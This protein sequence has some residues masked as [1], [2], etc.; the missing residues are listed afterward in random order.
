MAS[1]CG[2][3]GLEEALVLSTL[4]ERLPLPERTEIDEARFHEDEEGWLEEAR[5]LDPN[6]KRALLDV[7]VI[8]ASADGELDVFEQRF[9]RRVARA[10]GR[11]IDLTAVEREHAR[12]R[13]GDVAGLRD[14]WDLPLELAG[15]MSRAGE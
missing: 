3:L 4:I 2:P 15:S 1:G 7:L 9:L 5:A 13:E 6:S 8:V 10:L 11:E 12:L 14:E